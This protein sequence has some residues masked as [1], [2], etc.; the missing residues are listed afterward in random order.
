MFSPPPLPKSI[1]DVVMALCEA[2]A[3]RPLAFWARRQ[4]R[5]AQVEPPEPSR[6]RESKMRRHDAAVRWF[7]EHEKVRGAGYDDEEGN[8]QFAKWFHGVISRKVG[9]RGRGKGSGPVAQSLMCPLP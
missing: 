2:D 7:K 5:D 8:D 6:R 3:R 4:S 9:G 1:R